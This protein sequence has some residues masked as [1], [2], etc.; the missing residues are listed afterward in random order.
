MFRYLNGQDKY[1][2]IQMV[3]KQIYKYGS[4]F[5]E[6]YVYSNCCVRS[7]DIYIPI[8]YTRSLRFN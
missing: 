6:F 2:D 7:E 3:T 8:K 5:K 4:G 1:V